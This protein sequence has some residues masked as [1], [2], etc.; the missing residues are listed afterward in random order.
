MKYKV[1]I[2]VFYTQMI[3]VDSEVEDINSASDAL[4][5]AVDQWE[6]YGD[7]M[8]HEDPD[9]RVLRIEQYDS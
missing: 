2:E 1:F 9:Y 7:E 4:E 8:S 5:S 3:E 6:D